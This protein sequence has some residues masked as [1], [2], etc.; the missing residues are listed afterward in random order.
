MATTYDWSPFFQAVNNATTQWGERGQYQNMLDQLIGKPTTTPGTMGTSAMPGVTTSLNPTPPQLP[1][2]PAPQQQSPLSLTSPGMAGMPGTPNSTSYGGMAGQALGPNAASLLPL[3][4]G[5]PPSVGLPFLLNATTKNMDR[6]QSIADKRITP[7]TDAEAAANHL[8]PGGVYGKDISGNIVPIQ[9]SDLVSDASLKQKYDS[10]RM[11]G[12]IA[13]EAPIT[14][15]QNLAHQDRVAQMNKPVAI[16]Y[17][18]TL[19]NPMNGKVMG[20]GAPPTPGAPKIDASAPNLTGQTGLSLGGFNYLIGNTA[21][22]PRDARSRREA[23]AEA[24]AFAARSGTDISSLQ[25]QYKAYNNVLQTNLQKSNTMEILNKEVQGT[26]ENLAPVAD[27]LGGG[28]LK[29]SKEGVQLVGR[30]QNDPNSQQYAFYLNQLRA[31]LAGFNAV[32][33][34]K[35]DQHGNAHADDSDFRAAESVIRDGLNS[36]GARGLAAAVQA[37]GMK[38]KSIVDSATDEA[39]KGIWTL[40]GV[41]QNYK[42]RHGNH[43]APGANTATPPAAATKTIGGV[44]YHLVN[45]KWMQ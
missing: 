7:M 34:G 17:G 43:D 3:L 12:K 5:L 30:L 19:V 39:N 20:G 27:K 1:G 10:L 21:A 11:Q 29:W 40:F 14:K 28:D 8:R 18:A 36:G 32:S 38:N 4:R 31:D 24:D 26:V 15:E 16:P 22:I 35:M 2:G 23:Q 6:Q 42:P 9:E 41:G 33:G 37:T 13:A 45:G 25:S 44:T